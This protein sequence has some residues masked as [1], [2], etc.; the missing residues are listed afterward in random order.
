MSPPSPEPT[1]SLQHGSVEENFVSAWEPRVALLAFSSEQR[2]EA[3]V[4]LVG[5]TKL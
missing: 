3:R 4:T 5:L 2:V 1:F